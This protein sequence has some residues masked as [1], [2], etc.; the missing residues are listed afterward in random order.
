M[1]TRDQLIQ[2]SV[3]SD[4]LWTFYKMQEWGAR[5]FRELIG[6]HSDTTIH[7]A[8]YH[9]EEFTIVEMIG[10]DE[11][12]I[13]MDSQR[14]MSIGKLIAHNFPIF[15]AICTEPIYVVFERS[16]YSGGGHRLGIYRLSTYYR[17]VHRIINFWY[18]HAG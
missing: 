10:Q 2:D 8:E 6:D 15:A 18:I 1:L 14:H 13:N 12:W 17:L 7:P 11:H 9:R 5:H 16:E 4:A 3:F